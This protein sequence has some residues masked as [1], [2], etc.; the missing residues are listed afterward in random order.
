[1]LAQPALRVLT[2][3]LLVQPAQLVAQVLL[4]PLVPQVL[5][6]LK[7]QQVLQVLKAHRAF[8]VFKVFKVLLAQLAQ[9]VLSA[10]LVLPALLVRLRQQLTRV[11]ALQ[12]L[13]HRLRSVS[14]TQLDLLKS[15]KTVC[16]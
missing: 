16:S 4:V 8:K 3:Q 15:I 9:Q 14:R 1:L 11:Q 13:P 5:K 12:H 2:L 6:V 10:A 7:A